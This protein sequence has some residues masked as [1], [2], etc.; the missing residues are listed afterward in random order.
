MRAAAL[1]L[2]AATVEELGGGREQTGEYYAATVPGYVGQVTG[3]PAGMVY[4][5]A[6]HTGNGAQSVAISLYVTD[7]AS[8][9][10]CFDT[11]ECTPDGADSTYVRHEDRHGYVVRRDAVNVRVLGGLLVDRTLLRKAAQ[12]ARPATDE[13]LSRIHATLG[14]DPNRTEL[15]MPPSITME[16]AKGFTLYMVKAVISGRADEVIDLARTNLWR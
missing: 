11:T 2:R 12:E 14:R 4:S 7:A 13:E 6:D 5:P 16:M 8:D 10:I 9:S 1:S 15:A 3:S